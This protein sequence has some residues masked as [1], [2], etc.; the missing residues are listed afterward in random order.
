ML[1]DIQSCGAA[2]QH[3]VVLFLALIALV[4][5][6]LAGIALMRSVD[7]TTLIAGNLAFKQG[8]TASAD[9]GIEAGRTWLIANAGTATLSNDSAANGY[10]ATDQVSLD[11][12]GNVDWDG[13][14]SGAASKAVI[15][16]DSALP[17]ALKNKGYIVSY[18]I[19]RLCQNSGALSGGSCGTFQESSSSGG[20][21]GGGGIK[22]LSGVLQGNYR[23]TA[24]V[25]GPKNAI[26]FVQAVVRI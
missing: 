19:H 2:K 6:T 3:G 14:N 23:I 7:T 8:A 25:R 9:S 4:S 24:R 5:M 18:I 21:Q 15:L 11:L 26:S 17:S 1:Y 10:Y 20:T 22:A 12:F 16:P 13:T